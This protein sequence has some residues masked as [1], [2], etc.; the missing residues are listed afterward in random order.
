MIWD[1]RFKE[2]R[3]KNRENREMKKAHVEILLMNKQKF[4]CQFEWF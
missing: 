1:F 4:E 2:E 3:T